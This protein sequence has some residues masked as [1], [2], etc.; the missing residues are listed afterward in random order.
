MSNWKSYEKYL[1]DTVCQNRKNIEGGLIYGYRYMYV[2][3]EHTSLMYISYV[4]L[5][6]Y[7]KHYDLTNN[8]Q[9]D[10]W[11][12]NNNRCVDDFKNDL[13]DLITRNA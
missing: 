7:N 8:M 5:F 3:K 13:F 1:R 10:F 9:W 4:S 12:Y 2:V 6:A 11:I